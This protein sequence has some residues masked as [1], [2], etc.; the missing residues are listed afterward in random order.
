LRPLSSKQ[1]YKDTVTGANLQYNMVAPPEVVG[2]GTTSAGP[3]RWT[4]ESRLWLLKDH[5]CL[6]AVDPPIVSSNL[7][8]G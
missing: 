2:A 3:F 4:T 7:K 1:T 8:N 5:Y 6:L